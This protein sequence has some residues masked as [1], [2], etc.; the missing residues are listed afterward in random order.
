M[1]TKIFSHCKFIHHKS[2]RKGFDDVSFKWFLKLL[3]FII[4]FAI[5]CSSCNAQYADSIKLNDIR[6]LASHNS[7]KKKPD[8]KV[9]R[10]L[11]RFKKRLGE[12]L[13][14]IQLDYGHEKLTIQLDSFNV[15]GFE[16]DL[17]YDPN[18]GAY[19]KRRINFFIPGLKQ[20]SKDLKLYQP[21]IKL[22]HIADI[23]YETNYLTFKEALLELKNWS[24]D[25]PN[26][27]PLFVNLEIKRS[28]PGDYS[29]FL[30]RIGFKKAPLTDT[31]IFEVIENEITSVFKADSMI[32]KPLDLKGDYKSI[33]ERLENEGW[34]K[35]NDCL[36]K[37]IFIVDGDI[38]GYYA[39]EINKND[40]CLM[41]MYSEPN[42][43]SCAFVI[44]NE[45]L[46]NE[47]DIYALSDKYIVRTRT[48][49]GT[50]EA[51]KVDY[52]KYKVAIESQAQIVSTDYY[53]PDENISDFR[54][55]LIENFE[56]QHPSFELR[57]K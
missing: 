20:K 29:K 21:G 53:R 22:L 39:N 25:N 44:R 14:P 27:I 13:D 2:F 49:A 31:N 55:L 19:A 51:R 57:K 1:R 34:P 8:P 56:S 3:V 52:R 4:V 42:D 24:T 30:N 23:D 35:L 26:H 15:R 33:Q 32:L 50:I 17:A 9:L 43:A 38:D 41:F 28:S 48:D 37:I 6:V 12:D 40:N 46:G 54:V 11:S 16:F 18:G 47:E 10:F 45:P 7:Y 36:G 5:K